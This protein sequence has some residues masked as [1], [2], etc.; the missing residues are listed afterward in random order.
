MKKILIVFAAGVLLASCSSSQDKEAA[1][2]LCEH[3]KIGGESTNFIELM[4]ATQKKSE[5]LKEWQA[6]YNGKITD[7]FEEELKTTCPDGHKSATEM[8]LFDKKGE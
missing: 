1:A 8:G 4:E 5:K 7:G 2:E 6:K 3:L